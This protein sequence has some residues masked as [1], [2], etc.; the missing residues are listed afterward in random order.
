MCKKIRRQKNM[1]QAFAITGIVGSI[2][3][4]V[5]DYFLYRCQGTDNV[6]IGEAKKIESN[7][8]KIRK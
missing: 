5:G 4:A 8:E 3:C 6:R 1:Y 7:W 2:I